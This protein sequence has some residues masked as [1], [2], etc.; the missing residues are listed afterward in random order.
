MLLEYMPYITGM[1]CCALV[2]TALVLCN[3]L[4]R[5]DPPD[6]NPGY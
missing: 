3:Y 4:G 1:V 6:N 5:N 2:C